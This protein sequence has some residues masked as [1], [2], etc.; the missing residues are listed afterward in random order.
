MSDHRNHD[1]VD[2]LL[3]QAAMELADTAEVVPEFAD[4]GITVIT[5]LRPGS[6]DMN[7]KKWTIAAAAAVVAI[8][9]VAAAVLTQGDDDEPTAA[10]AGEVTMEVV[11]GDLRGDLGSGDFTVTE[12]VGVL[13]CRSGTFTD[14]QATYPD[15]EPQGNEPVIT[16]E[17]TCTTGGDNQ[18]TFTLDFTFDESSPRQD[19]RFTWSVVDATGDYEGLEG[20]GEARHDSDATLIEVWVGALSR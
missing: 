17:F 1:Q 5:P 10:V 15:N 11:M 20:Q 3:R 14:V 12:G 19:P 13:G 18:G 2:A 6:D 4:L 9:A 8:I 16:R 7:P